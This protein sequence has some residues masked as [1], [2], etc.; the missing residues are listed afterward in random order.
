MRR[1]IRKPIKIAR[2]YLADGHHRL[3]PPEV[4]CC[5]NDLLCR[6][7]QFRPEATD[8]GFGRQ[9]DVGNRLA[10]LFVGL[11]PQQLWQRCGAVDLAERLAKRR[12]VIDENSPGFLWSNQASRR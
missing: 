6:V 2:S 11:F 12:D 7:A 3:K 5:C 8:V 10:E 4:R 9:C 1:R